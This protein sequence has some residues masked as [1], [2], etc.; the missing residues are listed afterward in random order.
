MPLSNFQKL[1]L[2]QL[3]I[4]RW[5]LRSEPS[6]DLADEP[7]TPAPLSTVGQQQIQSHQQN[8]LKVVA[9]SSE[10]PSVLF[11]SDTETSIFSP[12]FIEDLLIAI[13]RTAASWQLLVG[14][15]NEFHQQLNRCEHSKIGVMF[16]EAGS[17]TALNEANSSHN[18]H[19]KPLIELPITTTSK[20]L[21]ESK[22]QLWGAIYQFC[23]H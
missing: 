21:S 22:K 15:E 8:S 6:V 14:N 1:R 13:N 2:Q 5:E 12:L 23:Y 4:P 10:Q 18:K 3:N 16:R 20:N 17:S 7:K 19:S 9:G 11:W